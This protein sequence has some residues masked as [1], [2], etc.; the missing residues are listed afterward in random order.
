MLVIRI[1]SETTGY[2]DLTWLLWVALGFF[3]IMVVVGWLVS[4]RKDPGGV[5]TPHHKEKRAKR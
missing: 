3:V 1:L 2:M 5:E 4:R